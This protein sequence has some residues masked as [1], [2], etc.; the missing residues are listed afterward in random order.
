MSL[1][2]ADKAA[3]QEPMEATIQVTIYA[4]RPAIIELIEFN[5][6]H[7]VKKKENKFQIDSSKVDQNIHFLVLLKQVHIW[8]SELV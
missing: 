1:D 5:W 7:H 3:I 6:G 8:H 4:R 2:F